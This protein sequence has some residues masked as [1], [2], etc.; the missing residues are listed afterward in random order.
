MN[1]RQESINPSCILCTN[2]TREDTVHLRSFRAW[3]LHSKP[4]HFLLLEWLR[5]DVVPTDNRYKWTHSK[6][7][8]Y[9]V[10]CKARSL[11][12][13]PWISPLSSDSQARYTNLHSTEKTCHEDTVEENDKTFLTNRDMHGH[14]LSPPYLQISSNS[15]DLF[16]MKTSILSLMNSSEV[17]VCESAFRSAPNSPD[18]ISSSVYSFHGGVMQ[19]GLYYTKRIAFCKMWNSQE[20]A[21]VMMV[22]YKWYGEIFQFV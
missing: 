21:I 6:L 12:T 17:S 20:S 8:Q 14:T 4:E 3:I 16:M 11:T 13:W 5:D 9:S 1:I 22:E 10:V 18:E 7:S 2:Q 15:L 19:R